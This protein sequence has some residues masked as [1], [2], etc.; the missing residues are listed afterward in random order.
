[1]TEKP[2]DD[3]EELAEAVGQQQGVAVS[4]GGPT[5]VRVTPLQAREIPAFARAV[6]PLL[7]YLRPLLDDGDEGGVLAPDLLDALAEHGDDLFD[8]V[9]IGA[10]LNRE[11]VDGLQLDTLIELAMTVLTVNLDFFIK[12]L[13]PML[14]GQ[15]TKLVTTMA[16]ARGTTSGN[17]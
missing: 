5:P 16:Q 3:I 2:K 4:I 12:R 8:A 6:R 7:P 13:V 9:A 14:K 11:A 10:R 1:M 17:G 15:A